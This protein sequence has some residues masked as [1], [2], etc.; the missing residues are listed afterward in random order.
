MVSKEHYRLII[1]A[2]KRL[3]PMR[4]RVVAGLLFLVPCVWFAFCLPD[5]LFEVPYST[6]LLDR[7][8]HLLNASVASDGQ[9]RFPPTKSVPEKF[10]QAIIHYEDRRFYSHPGI[11]PL[12]MLRA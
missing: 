1:S 5:T 2:V 4:R 12:A 3:R 6:V 10:K 11:D 7:E 8:G 9:W